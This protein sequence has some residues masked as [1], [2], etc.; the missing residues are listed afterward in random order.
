VAITA[1]SWKMM[2][3]VA[4]A[5]LRVYHYDWFCFEFDFAVWAFHVDYF[6]WFHSFAPLNL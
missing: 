3:H 4:V 5:V 1:L 6:L 2:F